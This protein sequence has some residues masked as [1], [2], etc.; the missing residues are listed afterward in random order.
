MADGQLV[1]IENEGA[2][3][4]GFAVCNPEEVWN[5]RAGKWQPYGGPVPKGIGWGEEITPAEFENLK[6]EDRARSLR[7][8]QSQ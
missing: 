7:A 3:F 6:A 8:R 1:L 2:V 5:F 4:R